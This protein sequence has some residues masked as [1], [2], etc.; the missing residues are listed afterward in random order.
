MYGTQNQKYN[1][2]NSSKIRKIYIS[3]NED[4]KLKL[5]LAHFSLESIDDLLTYAYHLLHIE[6]LE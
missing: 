6:D 1:M 2:F 4:D 3:L 5:E